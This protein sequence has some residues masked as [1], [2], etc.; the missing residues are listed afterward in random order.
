MLKLFLANKF[1]SFT[2]PCLHSTFMFSTDFQSHSFYLVIM[3]QTVKVELLHLLLRSISKNF[4]H[5]VHPIATFFPTT[6]SNTSHPG[7]IWW[8]ICSRFK[9]YFAY[10]AILIINFTIMLSLVLLLKGLALV[11]S[12]KLTELLS[13][14][15]SAS[16]PCILR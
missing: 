16:F 11:S 13:L 12:V 5:W 14:F 15:V 8:N 6:Y 9:F 1:T 7:A 2:S 3:F 4:A 10:S